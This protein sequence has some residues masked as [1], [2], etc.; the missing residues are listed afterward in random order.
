MGTNERKNNDDELSGRVVAGTPSAG[1]PG[2]AS[3]VARAQ[4]SMESC[5]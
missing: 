4:R 1:T 3:G 2:I 5:M